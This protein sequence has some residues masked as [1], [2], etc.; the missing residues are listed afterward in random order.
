MERKSMVGLIAI[1]AVVTAVMFAG[2]VEDETSVPTPKSTLKPESTVGWTYNNP[3]PLGDTVLSTSKAFQLTAIK[4]ERGP[5]VNRAVAEA[6]EFNDPPH[7]GNE[8]MFVQIGFDYLEG[9]QEYPLW[10]DDFKVYVNDVALESPYVVLPDDHP[11]IFQTDIMP[12]GKVEKW[13]CFEVPVGEDVIL[14][15]DREMNYPVYYFEMV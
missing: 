14:A 11:A 2:C 10:R 4:I 3:A 12:G 1:V 9:D 5:Q 6:N 7:V 13:L 8:Y 15:Y